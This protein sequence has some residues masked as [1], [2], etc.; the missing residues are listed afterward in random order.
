[1]PVMLHDKKLALIG[2]G[3]MG[4]AILKGLLAAALVKPEQIT[5][6]DIIETRLAYLRETYAVRALSDNAAAIAPADLIIL[7]VKP[8][9]IGQTIQGMAAA[10][11]EHKVVISIAAGVP[12]ARIE[13]AFGRPVRVVRVMPNTPALVLA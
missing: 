6:T 4:E 2:G 1:M 7:A 10:V 8:Q 5:V 12:T 13:A 11:D 3:N 9:D